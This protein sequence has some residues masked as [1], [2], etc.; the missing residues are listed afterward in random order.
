MTG[1]ARNAAERFAGA[2]DRLSLGVAHLASWG[3]PL[4]VALVLGNV[5]LRYGFGRGS[6]ELEELQWHVFAATVLLGL[7][8]T[9]AED[10]HVRVDL[11]SARLGARARARI[12][13]LGAGLA[14][15]PFAA[16][17]TYW[18]VDF[19]ARSWRLA[20]RSPMPSG[21]PA[22]WVIKGI[23]AAGMALLVLQA[24]AALARRGVRGVRATDPPAVAPPDPDA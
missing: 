20:E 3:Q 21:L 23:F 12:E 8:G 22:R 5:V 14:L 7:A 17:V 9:Y 15:L 6:I 16:L 18:A 19:F 11:V 13:A 24:L 2:V 1:R 4:L 10:A